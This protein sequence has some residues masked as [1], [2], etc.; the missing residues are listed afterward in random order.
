LFEEL[1]TAKG[2]LLRELSRHR[3]LRPSDQTM[4]VAKI[5]QAAISYGIPMPER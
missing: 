2:E 4:V 3:E 5:E 1:L